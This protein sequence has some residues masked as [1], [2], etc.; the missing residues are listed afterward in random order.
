MRGLG[1]GSDRTLDFIRMVL[2]MCVDICIDS[3]CHKLPVEYTL[4]IQEN[5]YEFEPREVSSISVK[6]W[7]SKNLGIDELSGQFFSYLEGKNTKRMHECIIC[8]CKGKMC[9]IVRKWRR[10]Y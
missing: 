5:S 4:K 2:C 3:C 10:V 8:T 6:R 7:K 9:F 1:R